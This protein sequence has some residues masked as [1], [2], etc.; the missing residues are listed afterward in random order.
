MRLGNQSRSLLHVAVAVESTGYIR[1]CAE[2]EEKAQADERRY[3]E[4][5]RSILTSLP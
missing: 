1:G 4:F 5:E 3:R 2:E